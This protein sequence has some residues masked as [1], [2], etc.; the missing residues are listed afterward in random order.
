[1]RNLKNSELL[2]LHFNN[3]PQMVCVHICVGSLALCDAYGVA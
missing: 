2:N 3:T 1:M